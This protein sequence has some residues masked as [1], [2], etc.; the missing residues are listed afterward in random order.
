MPKVQ[1]SHFYNQICTW[2][3]SKQIFSSLLEY[4]NYLR[5]LDNRVDI[6]KKTTSVI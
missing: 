4:L 5:R 3:A 1:V 2:G 6:I